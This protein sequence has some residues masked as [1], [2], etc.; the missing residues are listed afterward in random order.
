[1]TIFLLCDMMSHASF[2][3]I[4]I[5]NLTK[6]QNFL[7]SGNLE[8]S[9]EEF[10]SASKLKPS[11]SL[12]TMIHDGITHKKISPKISKYIPANV[13]KTNKSF[14]PL[15]MGKNPD[16]YNGGIEDIA[17][18]IEAS[19]VNARLSPRLY[20]VG[21]GIRKKKLTNI[22]KIMTADATSPELT[23][24]ALLKRKP[25]KDD[26]QNYIKDMRETKSDVNDWKPSR[27]DRK[28]K[29]AKSTPKTIEE[30]RKN[31]KQKYGIR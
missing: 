17:V 27:F 2:G 12:S 18:G 10:V 26:V 11:Y 8:K 24:L 15:N 22:E 7:K 19:G 28:T 9:A 13:P 23:S 31:L 3:K 5:K 20:V 29:G 6:T 21:R 14:L 4:N 16:K 1:M 25:N 30:K